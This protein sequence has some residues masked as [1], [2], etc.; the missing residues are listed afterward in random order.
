[1]TLSKY[2]LINYLFYNGL[3]TGIIRTIIRPNL[4]NRNFYYL[5]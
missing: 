5:P 4:N 2:V 1:M 3:R